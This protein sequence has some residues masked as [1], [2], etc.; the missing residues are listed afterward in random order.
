M[1]IK[2]ILI[3]TFLTWAAFD[4]NLFRRR[5]GSY[6]PTIIA[7]SLDHGADVLR[8]REQIQRHRLSVIPSWLRGSRVRVRSKCN[9]FRTDSRDARYSDQ[10]KIR[11][12]INNL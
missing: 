9:Y 8:E 1:K 6:A 10:R 2:T 11:R 5:A 3:S 4:Q 7:V 12:R